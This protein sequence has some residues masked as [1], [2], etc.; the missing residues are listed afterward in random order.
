MTEWQCKAGGEQAST[1]LYPAGMP[2]SHPLPAPTCI[3]PEQ[4]L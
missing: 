2:Q 1:Q 4:L 3:L